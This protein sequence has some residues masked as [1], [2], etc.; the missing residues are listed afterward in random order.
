VSAAPA[1]KSARADV[2]IILVVAAAD[3]GVIGADGRLPWRLKTELAHFR[4][5]TLGK[6]MVMGRKTFLSIGMP[7]KGRTNIVVSRDV[8]F[9]RPGVLV[10]PS[11][12]LGLA[13]ARGDALRRG[14]GEIA[15]IGGA[16]V[17]RQTLPLADRIV[18]TQVHM[19]AAGDTSF[20]AIDPQIWKEAGREAFAAGPNDDASFTVVVFDRVGA[21]ARKE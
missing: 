20:P 3:N 2:S 12:E 8:D 5:V 7:L 4:K 9:A 21:I 13:A 16:D 14:S 6:P 1:G 10:A 15:V 17:Y 19:Q 11:M 18:F